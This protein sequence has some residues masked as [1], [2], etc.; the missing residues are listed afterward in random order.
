MT[1]PASASAPAPAEARARQDGPRPPAAPLTRLIRLELSGILRRPRTWVFLGVLAIVPLLIGVGVAAGDPS[2][3]SGDGPGPGLIAAA[4]ANGLGLPVASL[5]VAMTLLLPLGMSV[6]AAD[7]L[8]GEAA[9]GVLR[10]LLLAPMGRL[11]LVLVKSS[12]VLAM[13]LVSVV[14][15]TVVGTVAGTLIIGG[16]DHLL[17]LSGSTVGTGEAL[18]RIGLAG[19]WTLLQLAAVGAVALAVSALTERPLVV[20]ALVLGGAVMCDVLTAIPSLGALH[21]WLLT[22]GWPAL[23]DLLRDPI[24]GQDLGHSALLAAVYLV[25]GMAVTVV[26]TL[27]R[28]A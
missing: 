25:L 19:V 4:T 20:T 17:T 13:A 28:E 15:I 8:A 23:A 24:P 27:R 2:A 21:P 7:A 6:T 14:V 18:R 16:A 22:A 11:R 9:H 10:G 3:A 5:A 26:A 12:G 1:T